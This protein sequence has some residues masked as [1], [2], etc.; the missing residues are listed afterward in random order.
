MRL[1]FK[2]EVICFTGKSKY[3]RYEMEKLAMKN[4]AV[5]A[6]NITSKTTLLVMGLRPGSKL[7]RAFSSGIRLMIDDEFLA[8]INNGSVEGN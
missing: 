2:N 5:V 3:T 7:G 4:G 6:K 1:I 8:I